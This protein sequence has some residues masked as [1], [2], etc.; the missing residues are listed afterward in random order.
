MAG[1]SAHRLALR[2]GLLLLAG[3]EVVAGMVVA[4]LCPVDHS[5]DLPEVGLWRSGAWCAVPASVCVFA[6]AMLWTEIANRRR[7]GRRS[8]LL[9]S[10]LVVGFAVALPVIAVAISISPCPDHHF[11][12]AAAILAHGFLPQGT[13]AVDAL[14]TG[15]LH[16]LNLLTAASI[17]ITFWGILGLTP[18]PLYTTGLLAASPPYCAFAVCYALLATV[19]TARIG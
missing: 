6:G 4:Q 12:M 19:A 18:G 10:D 2:V 3:G 17:P 1:I 14:T 13:W 5:P 7:A 8:R 15:I 11:L 16:G 9:P